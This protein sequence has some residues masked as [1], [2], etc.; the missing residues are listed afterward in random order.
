MAEEWRP[1]T[2]WEGRY[3][4]S[5]EGRIHSLRNR[6]ILRGWSAG[7][8]YLQVTLARPGI[9][10]KRYVHDLVI[11]TFLGN[12]PDPSWEVNH[13]NGDKRDNRLA[14][15]EWLTHQRNLQHAARTGLHNI[16]RRSRMLTPEQVL[17]IRA[18]RGQADYFFAKRFG[19]PMTSIRQVRLWLTY[20]DVV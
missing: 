9:R 2:G 3:E 19:V 11:R 1:I 20:R 6:L 12:P 16:G 7:A 15:L 10:S 18:T 8:G 17:E 13:R 5:S 14:N 4:V